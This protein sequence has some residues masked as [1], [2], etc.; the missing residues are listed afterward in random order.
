M[1]LLSELDPS[2]FFAESTVSDVEA[3]EFLIRVL[4]S[5]DAESAPSA[6]L[7]NWTQARLVVQAFIGRELSISN[8]TLAVETGLEIHRRSAGNGSAEYRHWSDAMMAD[9]LAEDVRRLI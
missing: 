6:C 7:S 9:Q 5:V 1:S 2:E 3:R 8:W 4:P